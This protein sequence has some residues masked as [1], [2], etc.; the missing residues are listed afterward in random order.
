MAKNSMLKGVASGVLSNAA[1]EWIKGLTGGVVLSTIQV[2]TE[3]V[4][5]QSVDWLGTVIFCVCSTVL[6]AVVLIHER[7]SKKSGLA[8]V[9][10]QNGE[11]AEA[12]E[13]KLT[14]A[15]AELSPF[16]T[17]QLEAFLLARDIDHFWAEIGPVPLFQPDLQDGTPSGI[18]K[19]L[20]DYNRR[21][22]PLMDKRLY[23]FQKSFGQR[24]EALLHG[25]GE[26]GIKNQSI[27]FLEVGFT[28]LSTEEQHRLGHDFRMLAV[29]KME[30]PEQLRSRLPVN[31]SPA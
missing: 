29:Q 13:R 11:C 4:R 1:W 17:L 21:L 24:V 31:R 2:V 14:D 12:R 25:F 22:T 9:N 10:A 8:P 19:A 27:R 7:R 23:G 28:Q 20:T 30:E 15:R 3:Y 26:R 18:E 6:I 5:R 16:T